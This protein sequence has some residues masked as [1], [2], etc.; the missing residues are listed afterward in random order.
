MGLIGPVHKETASLGLPCFP[1]SSYMK[2][3]FHPGKLKPR[4]S[5]SI[6]KRTL[7]N[8]MAYGLTDGEVNVSLAVDIAQL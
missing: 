2:K 1:A 3:V 7:R 4:M 6:A 5:G 8:R